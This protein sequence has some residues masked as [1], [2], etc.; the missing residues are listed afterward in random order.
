MFSTE[1]ERFLVNLVLCSLLC[2]FPNACTSSSSLSQHMSPRVFSL[3]IPWYVL[4]QF[5]K[6]MEKIVESSFGYLSTVL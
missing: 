2:D 3:A 4:Y 6:Y 1:M 5:N